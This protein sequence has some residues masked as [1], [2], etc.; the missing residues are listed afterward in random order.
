M[1]TTSWST[2]ATPDGPMRVWLAAPDGGP[3]RG[4]VLVLHEAFGVNEHIRD[5]TRRMAAEGYLALAP[6]LFH[7]TGVEVLGYDQ[8]AEAMTLIAEIGIEQIAADVGAVVYPGGKSRTAVVGFCFGGRA[9]FTA[10]IAIGGLSAAVV[11]Y[12]PGIAAGPHAVLD[13]VGSITAPVLLHTGAEDP[14]IPA[15]QVAATEDALLNAGIRF[16]SHVY[17]GAGHAFACDARPERFHPEAARQAWQRTY[18]FLDEQLKISGLPNL[19]AQPT[20]RGYDR[21]RAE[22]VAR[23]VRRR[24]A[25]RRRSGRPAVRRRLSEPQGHS[26]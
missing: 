21:L 19:E 11:F 12:G 5:V 4:T 25:V 13:R 14:S 10:A 8:Y 17:P 9:A 15:E 24:G 22:S 23:P 3:A 20:G 6:D 2:V 7:R 1:T 26:Q 18:R 16:E